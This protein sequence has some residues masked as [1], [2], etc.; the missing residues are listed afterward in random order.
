MMSAMPRSNSPS[1]AI[2]GIPPKLLA[3]FLARARREG[4]VSKNQLLIRLMQM[5]ADGEISTIPATDT[6]E[7]NMAAMAARNLGLPLHGRFIHQDDRTWVVWV[8]SVM[9]GG[10]ASSV[11]SLQLKLQTVGAPSIELMIEVPGELIAQKGTDASVAWV[12]A[13]IQAWLELPSDERQHRLIIT[14]S[15]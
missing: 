2:N 7:T 13:R 14:D 9:A 3:D 15:P 10:Q 12:V 4:W 1:L 6:I 11:R 8:Q 5:Y